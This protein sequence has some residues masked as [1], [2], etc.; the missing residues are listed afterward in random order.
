[1]VC[2]G[3][4][5]LFWREVRSAEYAE[6]AYRSWI[7]EVQSPALMH[8][9]LFSS[10]LHRDFKLFTSGNRNHLQRSREQLHDKSL[11]LKS[12]REALID[13]TIDYVPDDIL[14]SILFLAVNENPE[15]FSACDINPF[16]PPFKEP[17]CLYY[18]GSLDYNTIHWTFI[19][20]TIEYRGGLHHVKLFGSAYLISMWVLKRKIRT[21]NINVIYSAGLIYAVNTI[22][23]PIFPMLDLSGNPIAWSSPLEVLQI[24]ED[25]GHPSIQDNGFHQLALLEPP[26]KWDI[27]RVFLDLSE[28]SNALQFLCHYMCG[29]K[30]STTIR[31]CRYIL[32]HRLFSLPDSPYPPFL[33]L[34]NELNPGENINLT[35]GIYLSCRLAALLYSIHVTYPFP[36]TIRLRQILVPALQDNI[37]MHEPRVHDAQV[38]KI[39]LWC[40]MVGGILAE[41]SDRRQWFVAKINKLCSLLTVEN[42]TTM[43][44]LLKSFAWLDSACNQAGRTIWLEASIP[45]QNG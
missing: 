16:T 33:I 32:Q 10:S 4:Q 23:K 42:W 15:S 40:A 34:E 31:D 11:A 39:L 35:V 38:L 14:L 26:V 17:K 9:I 43:V 29:P 8:S 5:V 22:S 18:Y 19:Q 28:L 36:R 20:K 37:N 30:E 41:G 21:T 45:C 13:S 6:E 44:S 25:S 3:L 27:V 12:V 24:P 1:M 7:H 2:L